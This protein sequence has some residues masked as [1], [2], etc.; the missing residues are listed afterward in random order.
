VRLADFIDHEMKSILDAWDSFARKQ[1]PAAEHLDW[2]ALRDE[3][4]AI[5]RIVIKDLRTP[6][7][8]A[9]QH[10]KS[11][12]L[13]PKGR[14]PVETP[15]ESHGALRAKSGFDIK[16]LTA[17]YRALRANVLRLWGNGNTPEA[18]D[19]EDM[20][21]FNEAI[22]QA[23]TESVDFFSNR[24]NHER[25]IML[26]TLGHDMRSP[27]QVIQAAGEHLKGGRVDEHVNS[28]AVRITQSAVQLHALLDD[29]V[30]FNRM[31]L[32]LGLSI[33]PVKVDLRQL[34]ADCINQLRGADP[35]R[36][37]E[38]HSTGVVQGVWDS[39]RIH[40]LLSNLVINA[41]K[42]GSRSKPVRVS[43]AAKQSEVE[44]VVR[45]AGPKLDESLMRH[46]FEPLVRGNHERRN[47]IERTSL[48]LGLYI[49]RQIA[50]AHGGEISVSSDES[51]TAFAV[52]L[53]RLTSKSRASNGE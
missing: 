43:L 50:V 10:E 28:V 19:I 39:H 18:T 8:K 11:L 32:G 2:A 37:I 4:E 46:I 30:D 25:N 21:R 1:I 34:L 7:S 31:N 16:Q 22:D 27:L 9:A 6:Q 38:F 45:N 29:L 26:G 48:G 35:N 44:F 17:E 3:A 42:Y 5:L 36:E 33:A 51:E 12:G 41:L 47:A 49:A 20:T 53:P 14:D 40:Q 13:A 52:R 15:A 23:I 24:L